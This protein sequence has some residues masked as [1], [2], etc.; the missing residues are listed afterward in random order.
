MS[1]IQ[2]ALR[3]REEE[4]RELAP[5]GLPPSPPEPPAEPRGLPRAPRKRSPWAIAF[6]VGMA[7]V[8]IWLALAV[9]GVRWDR[10]AV[11]RAWET[12]A[13]PSVALRPEAVVLRVEEEPVRPAPPSSGPARTAPEAGAASPREQEPRVSPPVA[14][15]TPGV[16]SAAAPAPPVPEPVGLP[17]GVLPAASLAEEAVELASG[18][19]TPAGAEV[20]PAPPTP[21][22]A[23]ATRGTSLRPEAEWPALR[24]MGVLAHGGPGEGAAIINGEIVS[25]D[26]QVEGV[27]VAEVGTSGVWLEYQGR[28]RFVKVGRSTR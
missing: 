2:E 25:V 11:R 17:Y 4:R 24:V 6:G 27:T 26:E 18:V 5:V 7:V 15:T 12:F 9:G 28:K 8:G 20:V 10:R 21:A 1:L 14:P 13:R 22:R 19:R 16:A 3:R 23:E